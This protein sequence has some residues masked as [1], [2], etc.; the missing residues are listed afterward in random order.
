[1][2]SL[3]FESLCWLLRIELTLGVGGMPALD[4]LARSYRMRP[5]RPG[6]RPG[7]GRLCRAMEI[8]CALYPRHVLCL[9]RAASLLLLLRRHG[10]NA[11]L[12]LGAQPVPF[13]SHAWIEL[14]GTVV[15]DKPYMRELYQVLTLL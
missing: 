13:R 4:R 2:R 8:A 3:V 9:Q 15:G 11:S 12:V 6:S 7:P 14:N 1:M 10:W 5:A